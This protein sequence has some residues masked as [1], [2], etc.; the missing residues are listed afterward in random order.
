MTDTGQRARCRRVLVVDDERMLR[1]LF[2]T[3]LERA[4]HRVETVSG[5]EE[6]LARIRQEEFDVVFLDV[7]LS[8]G[9]DGFDVFDRLRE[10]R[11][12]VHVVLMTGRPSDERQRVYFDRADAVLTKPINGL[13]QILEAMG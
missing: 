2:T 11:P 13:H 10:L 12:E 5:G 8:M 1:D 7:L 6:A 4:G 9:L 3:V